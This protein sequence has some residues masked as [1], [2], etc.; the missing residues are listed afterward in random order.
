MAKSTNSS[1]NRLDKAWKNQEI[2]YNFEAKIDNRASINFDHSI[3]VEQ[4][5]ADGPGEEDD[6]D[7]EPTPALRYSVASLD[8][9][10]VSQVGHTIGCK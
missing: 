5:E 6:S 4:E 2:L 8:E 10:E 7:E 3:S 9:A 1:K